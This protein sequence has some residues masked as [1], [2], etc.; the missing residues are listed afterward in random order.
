M[1]SLPAKLWSRLFGTSG[2]EYVYALTTGLDGS[3]YVSG[4]TDG[5]LDGQTSSGG[6]MPL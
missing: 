5:S 3:I 6:T 2:S 4:S 1:S